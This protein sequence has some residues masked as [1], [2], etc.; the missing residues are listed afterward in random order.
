MDSIHNRNID[1]ELINNETLN[2][3]YDTMIRAKAFLIMMDDIHIDNL[4]ATVGARNEITEKLR[5]RGY[6]IDAIDA[7]DIEYNKR[8]LCEIRYFIETMMNVILAYLPEN[9]GERARELIEQLEYYSQPGRPCHQQIR[10]AELVPR[11]H[12]PPMSA[13]SGLQGPPYPT[14]GGNPRKT[15]KKRKTG[16]KPRKTGKRKTCEKRKSRK[17]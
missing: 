8:L 15:G 5:R 12:A 1:N 16:R 13:F 14:N 11:P 17:H 3:M 6:I 7:D 4:Q 2:N 10:R 9:R